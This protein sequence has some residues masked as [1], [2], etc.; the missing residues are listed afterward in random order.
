MFGS[1]YLHKIRSSDKF[2]LVAMCFAIF[3][4]TFI[5]GMVIFLET[6]ICLF[7]VNILDSLDCSNP[8]IPTTPR[9][10]NLERRRSK[11][12]I[13]TSGRLW[14]SASAII[15]LISDRIRS[16]RSP[17]LFGYITIAA[18]TLIFAFGRSP[19]IL[20]VA[21]VCQGLS[22][23]VIGVLG[24]AMIADTARPENTGEFMAYGSISFTWGMLMGPVFGGLLYDHFGS[25]GAFGLPIAMLAVDIIL[26][27]L[28]IERDNT[29][30]C[31]TVVESPRETDAPAV[32]QTDE[33]SPL[34]AAS[35]SH[36]ASLSLRNFLDTRLATAMLVE[37]TISS[38]ISVFETTL[39]LYTIETY[40]WSPTNSGLVFLG[41]T[42]PSFFSIP[43]ARYTADHGWDRRKIVAFELVL[44]SLPM[45]G[46][47]W[48][49]GKS[50][51]QELLFVVL[52]CFVGLFLTTCQAQIL[53]EV[54]ESV[55]QIEVRNGVDSDKSS[56]MGTG[57]AFCNMAIATG[58]FIGPLMAGVARIGLGWSTMTIMLGVLS[59][60]VGLVSFI[61][62]RMDSKN[63]TPVTAR[64]LVKS[65]EMTFPP[66]PS[67][68]LRINTSIMYDSYRPHP[69]LAQIPL[70][71][72]PFINLPTSVTLP[73]TY[74]SVTSI[75]PPS[76][77]VDPSNPEEKARYV[78][79][80]SGE[81]A[82]HPDDI[83]AACH[84]LETHL[85]KTRSD[86]DQAIRAWEESI[87]QRELAEKRR[88]APGWLD[89]E[90]KLLQPSRTAVSP[91]GGV[92]QSLLDSSSPDQSSSQMPAIQPHDEGEEL[93]RAFGGLGVK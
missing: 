75:L 64:Q 13:H 34:L 46:L 72:S 92:P 90:E 73:Y 88:L 38:V 4:D 24:L 60:T 59:S 52:I 27:V 63:I 86:A 80:S 67:P 54:S 85:S 81:H 32:S 51:Q 8:S 2:I 26:R 17:L 28:I 15:G 74:K 25:V 84:S 55:R 70:T 93:D 79:S 40:Q 10:S 82:A 53:A 31:S 71:V 50:L 65:A 77:T 37:V 9:G 35:H 78:V 12:D 58:Q 42:L 66:T 68:L 30:V 6:V 48:T 41:L 19:S 61:K 22:G 39:P 7:G 44:C 20:T 3:T 62:K 16:R 45:V 91:P 56:G 47:K 23:A 33:E 36:G 49:E 18:S 5:Y 43:L 21:R 11:M 1:N 83:L 76:V 29:S 69:L 89:R 87:K 57:F 14:S